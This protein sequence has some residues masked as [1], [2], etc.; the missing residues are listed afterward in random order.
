[1]PWGV[2]YLGQAPRL[3]EGLPAAEF[4]LLSAEL[5]SPQHMLPHLWRAS[6]WLAFGCYVIH[7]LWAL[8]RRE[9]GSGAAHGSYSY[10]LTRLTIVLALNLA[11]LGLAWLAVEVFKNPSITLFQPFRMATVLRG[12]AL[13]ALSGRLVF[14]WRRGRLVD[15]SRALLVAAGLAGDW[16]FVVATVVDLA[17]GAAEALTR[18]TRWAWG[19]FAV[20]LGG[21]LVFLARHD[22]ESGHVALLAVLV[23]AIVA[24]R[25]LRART[26]GWNRRRLG[27][28][29]G[30]SWAVPVMA[31]LA[32]CLANPQ[33]PWAAGLIERCRFTAVPTDDVERLALWCRAHTPQGARF[34]GPPGPKTFRLWSERNLAFNRAASPYHARGV[35][36]WAERFRAHVGFEGSSADLIRAYQ[37]DRHALERRYQ[38][39][40]DS[41]RAALATGQGAS[42]VVAAPPIG[43]DATAADS[44]LELLHVEGQ[45]AVYRVRQP[46]DRVASARV[47]PGGVQRQE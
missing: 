29:L 32:A 8:R 21:G 5:Q 43:R 19:A 39:L 35:A 6:Q 13:I 14:L 9:A 3:Y 41:G 10:S 23:L 47:Q 16:M 1:V 45:Y 4:L 30:A 46:E 15:R 38:A 37:H 12:L 2:L 42:Y 18:S 44:P 34:I 26:W 24:A 17:S 11:G 36:D 25:L 7:A 20:T 40:N 33:A 28:A 22:T 27:W 31:G